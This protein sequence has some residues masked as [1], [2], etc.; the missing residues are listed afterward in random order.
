MKE[1]MENVPLYASHSTNSSWQSQS[2]MLDDEGGFSSDEFEIDCGT[3]PAE[4]T[5][6]VYFNL[7][8]PSVIDITEELTVGTVR[9][10][11]LEHMSLMSGRHHLLDGI[12]KNITVQDNL[13]ETFH[14]VTKQEINIAFLWAA[15]TKRWDLLEG[16]I[17]LGAD[18]N[19]FEPSQGLSALHLVCFSGCIPGTQFLITQGCD[20]NAVYKSYA[21]LHCAAFG[22]SPDVAMI[23]LTN[24]ARIQT[25]T[26]TTCNSHESVLHCA[27]RAN[28]VACV[29]LFTH[30]GGDVGQV[31]YSGMS[32]IHLAADLGRSECLKILLEAKGRNVNAKTKGREQ[33]PLHLAA[34][35]GYAECVEILLEKGADPDVRN[36]M[37]QTPLHLAARAKAFQCV[38]LLL[39]KGKAN[40]NIED[41]DKRS[42]LHTAIGRTF[43]S[44]DIIEILITY[45]AHVNKI[46]QYGYTPLHIAA[47]NELSECVEI[48]I[49]QGADVTIKSKCGMTPL[50]IIRRK[51]PASLDVITKK[52]DSAISLYHHPK[53]SNH[54]V[55]LR[56]DFK[57]ILQHAHPREISFLNTFIDEGQKELL[58]HPLCKAFLYLKWGKIRKYYIARMFFCFIFIL[59]LSLYIL[60]ALAHNCYNQGQNAN[61]VEGLIELCEKNSMLGDMLRDNPFVIEMQWFVLV[62]ITCFEIIRKIYGLTGYSTVQQYFSYPENTLEWLVIVSV[63][64]ISFIYTG[65]TYTWQN[66]VGAFAVLFGWTNLMLMI[67][68]L[69]V[70]GI[71]VAMYTKVQ[72]EF[73]KL[74]LA[75]SCL[76]IGFAVSFCI[77]FPESSNFANPFV[78]LMTLIAM[79]SGELD[80]EMLAD[81]D[82]DDPPFFLEVSAQVTYTLFVLLVTIVL[83]NLLVGIAVDDIQGLQ[84]TAGLSKLVRQT[85]LISHIEVAL[86]NGH[87]PQYFLKLLHWTAL[88][89]PKAYRVVLNVKPLNHD[90]KRLP[91]DILEAAHKIALKNKYSKQFKFSSK[92]DE[93]R[94][95][96]DYTSYLSQLQSN[97]EK[98]DEQIDQLRLEIVDVK[99]TIERLINVIVQSR[100]QNN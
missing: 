34:E 30:E 94:E 29:R 3:P 15:F 46:D 14:G 33:T 22:D 81:E 25:L 85:K 86:F 36:H 37:S 95:S 89:S 97:I 52:L 38:E 11:L 66:H 93:K 100:C 27:V 35:K 8:T 28:A 57:Y 40:P 47:L 7:E 31:E 49:L 48:L 24:G 13:K 23:L 54:E 16:F 59:N 44:S 9:K 77:V 70:F 17:M 67:G 78:S 88:V 68:Q 58:L 82:T 1:K 73:A 42:S 63:F 84:K 51:I 75:Y 60:T 41:C 71:Y 18:T 87:L 20:V 72:A 32:P 50:A 99:N 98:R 5:S 61:D 76:L 64:V 92:L 80:L 45:G 53:S 74:L 62:G 19:Y 4:D 55:D 2:K 56:L 65:R 69:P 6:N 91:R 79:M 96:L 39:I 21:P 90:E 26:N 12:E 43:V 83:M 10:H